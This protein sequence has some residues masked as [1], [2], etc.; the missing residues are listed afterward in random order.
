MQYNL[1]NKQINKCGFTLMELI[2][3]IALIAVVS[4]MTLPPLLQWR[5]GLQYREASKGLVAALR[6][7]RS[8]AIT[9]NRQVELEFLGNSYRTRAG[10]RA[11]ASSVWAN[12]TWV[13]LPGT[14]GLNSPNS[15]IL[16]NPNGTLFFANLPADP[17]VASVSPAMTVFIQ[18]ISIAPA[19]NRYA[20]DFTQTGRVS[21]R[22]LN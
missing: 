18:N 21:V 11:V 16:A 5:E 14:V 20:I 22:Q 13:T 6:T 4:V 12:S 19:V 17:V 3:V 10:N 9:T 8:T 7:A 1:K 2:V 15:R